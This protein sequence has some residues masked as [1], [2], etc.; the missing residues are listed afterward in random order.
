MILYVTIAIERITKMTKP[1]DLFAAFQEIDDS[2]MIK[3][4]REEYQ[5]APFAYPGGKSKSLKNIL[6]HLPYRESYI[7]PFG[8]SG[9]V[10]IARRPSKLDVYNDRFAGVVAFYRCIQDSEKIM[11]L[12]NRL[13][14][15]I[16]SREEFIW[17]RDTWNENIHDDVERAARWYYMTAYSFSSLGRNFGRS[18]KGDNQLTKKFHRHV[19]EFDKIHARM[20]HCLIENQDWRNIL[21]D[22]DNHDAIFYLDPPYMDAYTGTY[23]DEI[24]PQDHKDMLNKVFAMDGFVAVSGYPNTLYD[25]FDWDERHTWDVIVSVKP[26]AFHAENRKD[27]PELR[28]NANEVLWIKK[29]R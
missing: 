29:E 2:T 3:A 1:F 26:M 16:H 23:K 25:S 17:C 10:L 18:I 21:E 20:K 9:A 15:T 13:E 24:K 28:N 12:V 22:F 27:K 8:G 19:L 4:K 7:E 11:K 5:R 14:D 6:P